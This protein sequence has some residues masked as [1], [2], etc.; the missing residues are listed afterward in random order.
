MDLQND[1]FPKCILVFEERIFYFFNVLER[2][3][4]WK[5]F[6]LFDSL[7]DV[8]LR[9]VTTLSDGDGVLYRLQAAHSPGSQTE[10]FASHLEKE[11]FVNTI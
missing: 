5:G 6:P 7:S 8:L 4:G 9:A 2:D 11:A 10:Q 1:C 3:L